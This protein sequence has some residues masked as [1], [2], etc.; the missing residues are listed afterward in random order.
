MGNIF[1]SLS[2]NITQAVYTIIPD[3]Y[4]VFMDLASNRYFS[5]KSIKEL[6]GNI[7]T[8]I[9]VCMLFALGIK[10]LSAIVN[11]DLLDDKKKGAKKVF[12]NCALS[13]FLIILIPIGFDKLYELQDDVVKN[14]LVEKLVLGMDTSEQSKPGQ[15]LAA[16]AFSS[17]CHPKDIVS[18][19]KIANSGGNLYNKA[20]QEDINLISKLDDV[21]VSKT[22][23]EYDIEYNTL[24]SPI[25][26][27]VLDYQLILLCMDTALRT[28]KLGLLELIA[29]IVLCGFI[30]AGSDL[31]QRWF[32]EVI[33]T[34]TL[35]FIKIGTVSFLVFGLSLLP[36]FL[37]NFS[38][39]SIF[40]RGFLRVFMLIGLLQ[41]IH[42]LP[43]LIKKI[44]NVDVKLRGGIRGR[45]GEMAGVGKLAQ[46]AWDKV[47]TAGLKIGAAG[48]AAVGLGAIGSGLAVTGALTGR[49]IWK[50]GLGKRGP[51]SNTKF[52]KGL[53]KFDHG[54][55]TFGAKTNGI[56]TGLTTK[57]GIKKSVNAGKKAYAETETGKYNLA[58]KAQR[59]RDK[60]FGE[61]LV[62]DNGHV[63]INGLNLN[64]IKDNDKRYNH[65]LQAYNKMSSSTR[66]ALRKNGLESIADL[67]EKKDIALKDYMQYQ[68]LNKNHGSV[69]SSIRDLSNT[70]EPGSKESSLINDIAQKFSDGDISSKV[71]LASLNQL[72]GTVITDNQYKTVEG[73]AMNFERIANS[74]K[75]D[76]TTYGSSVVLS[77]GGYKAGMLSGR[78]A[79]EKTNYETNE[80]RLQS[81]MVNFT[82]DEKKVISNINDANKAIISDF[83]MVSTKYVNPT[84]D[85]NYKTSVLT[86]AVPADLS[87][88]P[89]STPTTNNSQQSTVSGVG[90]VGGAGSSGSGAQTINGATINVTNLNADNI[91]AQNINGNMNSNRF[92]TSSLKGDPTSLDDDT[93]ESIK[94]AIRRGVN[95]SDLQAAVEDVSK[96]VEDNYQNQN[97]DDTYRNGGFDTNRHDSTYDDHN[98][99]DQFYDDNDNE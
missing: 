52:G 42:I 71:A 67:E 12:I 95:E 83:G 4:N 47:K 41:V 66:A 8:I 15:I 25:V 22:N 60:I 72:K 16:Y 5:E 44:F 19:E 63:E 57:G 48:A 75:S 80:A 2:F 81:Q 87:Y 26:G 18:S 97:T 35:L 33:S 37:N 78:E 69:V 29:P 94:D 54:V 45:L 56:W 84:F 49:H 14:Q 34:F 88:T 51:L 55:K 17:F 36:D 74:T 61:K 31:L 58:N 9:S 70:L 3:I 77:T 10:L 53:Q 92:D 30:F 13:V 24:I 90:G 11:P 46:N 89:S 7:Y 59:I 32:K 23:G 85:S 99:F 38:D 6:S 28:I 64:D 96:T 79:S 39:K 1:R 43:D 98:E 62:G 86:T 73:A 93:M 27:V 91:N 20:L 76:G 82:E 21:I 50:K 40:Y 65:V 68:L